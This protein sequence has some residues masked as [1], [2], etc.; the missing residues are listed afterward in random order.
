MST[1]TIMPKSTIL[2]TALFNL[3]QVAGRLGVDSQFMEKLSEPKEVINISANPL[4][5]SGRKLSF[6][7][8]I[9]RH[10]DAMGP[11]KGG[12]RMNHN[13]TAEDI[14]G[15]AMEMTWKTSLIGVPFGGG[16]S[17]ICVDAA[18]LSAADKEAVLRSFTRAARRHIGPE[19]YIP[20]PDMGT[21]E[22]D[23]G[24]IRD[25]IAYSSGTSITDGCFVTGKPVILGGIVGRRE[26][27]GKGVVYSILAACKNLGIDIANARVAVQGFGNVGSVAAFEIAR[28]G[29][30]VVAISD[31]EGGLLNTNGID[32][33][34]LAAHISQTGSM[35]DF[36]EAETVDNNSVLTCDCEILI[37]AASQS[38]ITKKNADGIKAKIIA[39][40]ANAPTMP[41]ADEILNLAGKCVI[42]DILCNA[43]GV[44]VSYLEY[45]QETQRE[46][47][48]LSQVESRLKERMDTKFAEVLNYAQIKMLN[49][50]QAAM[51]KAVSRVVDALE[52]RGFLP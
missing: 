33:A 9:V 44:F 28:C 12:I 26:A 23:M 11:A 40:G 13:V 50:R 1:K 45:T 27:T 2:E 35:R 8:F 20:A 32:M 38:Q 43:G 36:R 18:S 47:M 3:E 21:N 34:K 16:K 7:A 39:E 29:A 25:C 31:I 51:D 49:L 5:P 17:G 30:K 22:I 52:A 46:Q 42:P 10:N 14:T 19:I 6:K 4:L 15:L 48:T 24:H 37:P 41:E